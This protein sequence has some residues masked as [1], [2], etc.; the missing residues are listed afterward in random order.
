MEAP[1][2]GAGNKVVGG[3]KNCNATSEEKEGGAREFGRG[4]VGKSNGNAGERVGAWTETR[5]GVTGLVHGRGG[6]VR[7][8]AATGNR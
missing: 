4:G 2:L 8:Y 6:R 5:T 3:K 1:R 7:R